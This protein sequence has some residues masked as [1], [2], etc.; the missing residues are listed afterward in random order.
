MFIT[1]ELPRRSFF[2][3]ALCGIR[4]RIHSLR[5]FSLLRRCSL[6]RRGFVSYLLRLLLRYWEYRFPQWID[7]LVLGIAMQAAQALSP[8]IPLEFLG[9]YIAGATAGVPAAVL[10]AAAKQ[11]CTRLSPSPPC[12]RR[13]KG[14]SIKRKRALLSS[15]HNT[16]LKVT[17]L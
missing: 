4:G 2:R 15:F 6:V 17:E 1:R 9:L 7:N 11:Y 12:K 5:Q 10:P 3:P 8:R 14:L 16:F 13:K